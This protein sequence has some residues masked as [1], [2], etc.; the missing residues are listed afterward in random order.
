MDFWLWD[1]P[2]E[3]LPPKYQDRITHTHNPLLITIKTSHEEL[4]AIG[5]EMARKLN[6]SKGPVVILIPSQGFSAWD[7]PG[8]VFC[9]PEGRR[10]FT[11]ALKEAIDP[12]IEVR[13]L[14]LHIND[15]AF[16]QEAVA[17]LGSLL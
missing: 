3:T 6:V 1:G 16:A 11:E 17:A 7:K 8:G 10:V 13:E 2:K 14:D 9:N 4:A 15:I 5:K 12:K